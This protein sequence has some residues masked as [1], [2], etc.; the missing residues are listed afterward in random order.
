[1]IKYKYYKSGLDFILF[2]DKGYINISIKK[3]GV[4]DE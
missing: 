4:K 1:M 2:K 3:G